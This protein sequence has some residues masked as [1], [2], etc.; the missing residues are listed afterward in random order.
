MTLS[1]KPQND[2]QVVVVGHGPSGAVAAS[3]LGDRGIRTLA[4]DRQR[5][6]YDKPRAIAIDHEILRLLD[7]LGAAERVL[8]YIAPFPA[9]QHFGAKGQLIR[10]IDM[11][12]EPYPLGYTPSMVFT[13]PPVEAALREHAAAYDSVTVELGTELVGFEQSA[14]RVTL[15][16]RD[17]SG[18]TRD[19][20]ADYVIACDGASSGVRQQLDI[21]FEDL[22]FDEPWL[23][24]DLQVNEAA[25]GKLPETA[26][27]FCDPSRP[28][29]FIIGP[30]N[31]RRFEIMLL[32]GEDPREMET[33]AQVWRLLARWITPNDAT[34]WRAASY[35]FHALVA[36]EW[37]RG[38]IFLAG[39]AAHQQ[40]PFI[41]Q[42]MCQ[43]IR[44]VGNLVWKLDRVLRGQSDA[45]LLDTYGAERSEHVRQLTSRIKA[46]G[47]VICERDPDAA[48][49]RDE[50]ILA[51]GG[52]APRTITRQEIVPPLQ[53]GLLT[54]GSRAAHG[55]LFPQPWVRTTQ[56][57]R[58][59]DSVAGTGW[60]LVLDTRNAPEIGTDLQAILARLDIRTIRIGSCTDDGFTEEDGVLAAWFDR[61]DCRAALVRPDH[62]VFGVAH[63]VSTLGS[64]LT[65]L[66][67]RLR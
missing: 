52:G 33:A 51:E 9:S 23:V 46:I 43:G 49:V 26:A 32:P 19:V 56:G 22:V 42:G 3:L 1:S 5:E 34:L 25:L 39:D 37:R 50:R 6:V 13:Q 59:L 30:G 8:P 63:D 67:E 45:G 40:P 20:T 66:A 58:R 65:D 2:F 4:I 64:L 47:H 14:D 44:D 24:V 61:H 17:D 35:R 60:R 29:T 7:N 55:T 11:V 27:Q 62:Y 10:R 57:R 54:R 36:Q 48:A 21:A 12:A 18:T 31:H 28:T 38:R 53:T 41:G 15:H 16:L